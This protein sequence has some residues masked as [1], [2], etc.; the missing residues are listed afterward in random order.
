MSNNRAALRYA[1]AFY[2]LSQDNKSTDK[3]YADMQL[4]A[5]TISESDD[6]QL[7]LASTV[8]KS[9]EK[10]QVLSAIFDGKVSE[11][12]SKLVDLLIT[13]KRISAY[14]SVANQFIALYDVENG[15]QTATVTTAVALDDSTKKVVLDKVKELTGKEAI[16]EN[17]IDPEIIGGFI[18]RIG[19]IQFDSSFKNKLQAIK[20]ELIA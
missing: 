3:A 20:R 7:V 16:L 14:E 12:T 17:I 11:E 9:T 5:S 4:V 10:K 15:K 8:V 19:D 6:L 13:N 1:K 18:L 2:S